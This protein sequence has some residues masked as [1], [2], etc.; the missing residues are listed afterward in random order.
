MLQIQKLI[1]EHSK[2]DLTIRMSEDQLA[3]SQQNQE[4]L[5]DQVEKLTA[6]KSQLENKLS[7]ANTELKDAK[8]DNKVKDL[9]LSKSLVFE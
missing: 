9:S 6:D 7:V 8:Y 4:Y 2:K 5:M 1:Q 3:A